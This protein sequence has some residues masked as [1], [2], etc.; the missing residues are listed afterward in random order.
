MA[1]AAGLAASL[2]SLAS[3]F[4]TCIECFGYYRAAK[5]CPR[6]IKTKLVKLDF[7]K[8]RLLIWANEVGLVST[9][10]HSRKP[11]LERHE[12][13]LKAT[14]EQIQ[15]LL[16]DANKIQDKYGVRQQDEPVTIADSNTELVSRNSF[17]TFMAAFRRFRGKFVNPESSP[18]LTACF[19]WAIADETKFEVL[20]KTL[21]NFVDNLFWLVEVDRSIQDRIVEEDIMAVTTLVDLETIKDAS[22]HDYQLWSDVASRAVDRTEAST[23]SHIR[24]LNGSRYTEKLRGARMTPWIIQEPRTDEIFQDNWGGN[25]P[26][27]C[28]VLTDSCQSFSE[29][30]P[31]HNHNFGRMGPWPRNVL[32]SYHAL[33]TYDTT[34][35]LG[36]RLGK[37]FDIGSW[38][39][40]DVHDYLR[41]LV[42]DIGGGPYG[43]HIYV[44]GNFFIYV[45]PCERLIA[46]ALCICYECM[47]GVGSFIP[48]YIRVD[49]RLSASCCEPGMGYE[50]LVSLKNSLTGLTREQRSH[51]DEMW[52]DQRIH[53]LED[54]TTQSRPDT[55]SASRFR[56][57][58][59][60]D[61]YG[62]LEAVV[63]ILMIGEE[64][65]IREV[66]SSKS[67]PH[68][69]H[70]PS[71]TEIYAMH[72]K[73]HNSFVSRRFLGTYRRNPKLVKQMDPEPEASAQDS[74][75]RSESL[76]RSLSPPVV[77][78]SPKRRKVLNELSVDGQEAEDFPG[79]SQKSK[80]SEVSPSNAD[81]RN[82]KINRF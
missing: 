68:H 73:N 13:Q 16:S 65:E 54:G 12:P 46:Q 41:R 51:L 43:N 9:D 82:A 8:T 80:S 66:M 2:I 10:A 55:S 79:V 47:A 27:A 25:R 7:E 28:F 48:R 75:S 38:T 45:A 21:R 6:Q 34:S 39:R 29:P 37:Q 18:K 72:H 64:E 35:S 23:V 78:P 58:Y 52:L 49:D 32:N 31:C 3:L 4:S 42:L 71:A 26:S 70:V 40:K 56:H 69:P 63:A 1:E 22:E 15:T 77:E 62:I 50:R 76:I 20:I 60:E 67:F 61:S 57:C 30:P 19:R 36:G 59:Q 14:L 5:N 44:P 17:D 74:E 33:D 81:E 53:E 24:S 11:D